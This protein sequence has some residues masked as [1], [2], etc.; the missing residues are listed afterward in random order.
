MGANEG[1]AEKQGRRRRRATRAGANV[2]LVYDLLFV[3]C[4]YPIFDLL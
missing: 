4:R 1:C 3:N 2:L